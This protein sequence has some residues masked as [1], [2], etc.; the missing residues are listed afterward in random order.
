MANAVQPPRPKHPA[1]FNESPSSNRLPAPRHMTAAADIPKEAQPMLWE[2]HALDLHAVET[3]D[4]VKEPDNAVT[5]FSRGDK[6]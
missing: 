6:S 3:N 5:H 1:I 2:V 4:I